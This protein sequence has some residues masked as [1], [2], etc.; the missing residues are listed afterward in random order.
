MG[1]GCVGECFPSC[2]Y[3]SSD[4]KD[5]YF[6]CYFLSCLCLVFRCCSHYTQT[7]SLR[8]RDL[9][10]RF[11]ATRWTGQVVYLCNPQNKSPIWVVSGRFSVTRPAKESW[12]AVTCSRTRISRVLRNAFSG[13]IS[14]FSHR[15]GRLASFPLPVESRSRRSAFGFDYPST[16]LH[17]LT[18]CPAGCINLLLAQRVA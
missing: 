6:V 14:R 8:V 17:K 9:A 4:I 16:G 15:A 5:S 1:Y 3:L 11:Y 13:Q 10:A 7:S 18:T 2:T 12:R